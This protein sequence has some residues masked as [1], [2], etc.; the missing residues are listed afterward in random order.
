MIA[1]TKNNGIKTNNVDV[2]LLTGCDGLFAE[3]QTIGVTITPNKTT[4][5]KEIADPTATPLLYTK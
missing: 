5:I 1:I 3:S 2:V 4:T